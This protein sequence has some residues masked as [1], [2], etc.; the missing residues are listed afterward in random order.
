M[1]LKYFVTVGAMQ[2]KDESYI[3][4]FLKIFNP[5]FLLDN[6]FILKTKCPGI[7]PKQA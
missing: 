1:S 3:M 4:S 7:T 2:L 6:I 5:L